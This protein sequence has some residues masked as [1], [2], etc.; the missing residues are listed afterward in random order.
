LT[1]TETQGRTLGLS[2]EYGKWKAAMG[3]PW[4]PN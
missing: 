3:V 2:N 4:P 1:Q